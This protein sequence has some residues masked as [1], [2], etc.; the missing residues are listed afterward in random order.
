MNITYNTKGGDVKIYLPSFCFTTL[1]CVIQI[2]LFII[3]KKLTIYVV[4]F[5]SNPVKGGVSGFNWFPNQEAANKD[6]AETLKINEPYKTEVYQGS[7]EVE[8]CCD[9][10]GTED[11]REDVTMQAEL[12]LEE[13]DWE[14]SF[15]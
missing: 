15:V 7:I 4:G 8:V 5:E 11:E 9:Y 14:S 13:N 1:P 12:F 10:S 2:K 3:M 6:F